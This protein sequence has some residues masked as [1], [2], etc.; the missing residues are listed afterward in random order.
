[1]TAALTFLAKGQPPDTLWGELVLW[2][3]SSIVGYGNVTWG[4]AIVGLI[5]LAAITAAAVK[6]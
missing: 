2:W 4:A 3:N 6:R 5:V 1:M